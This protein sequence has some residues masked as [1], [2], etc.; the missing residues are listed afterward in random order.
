MPFGAGP[1]MVSHNVDKANIY[2]QIAHEMGMS[3]PPMPK[4]GPC[5]LE[6]EFCAVAAVIMVKHFMD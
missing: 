1:T 2:L 6:D 5:K 4:L 3:N